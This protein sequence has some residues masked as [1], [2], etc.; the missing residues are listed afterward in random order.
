MTRWTGTGAATL[1][2]G[3]WTLSC[4]S[5]CGARPTRPLRCRDLRDLPGARGVRRL[6]A[7][8]RRALRRVGRAV[9]EPA[10]APAPGRC[11][12]DRL[13]PAS[14]ASVTVHAAG[15]SPSTPTRR[16]IDPT[17]TATE[18]LGD[19]RAARCAK[20]GHRLG[21][22]T[23]GR[24]RR[25]GRRRRRQGRR[26]RHRAPRRGRGPIQ[27]P[28]QTAPVLNVTLPSITVNVPKQKRQKRE[29]QGHRPLSRRPRRRPGGQ[30]RGAGT[31]RSHARRVRRRKDGTMVVESL[32][33]VEQAGRG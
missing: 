28:S 7:G 13:V 12:R 11:S 1:R 22:R 10:Q 4:S 5:R 3:A 19:H 6:R 33:A 26:V 14:V 30:R 24:R 20:R 15:R 2:A 23:V 8:P 17:S 27:R 18:L 31:H 29:R 21:L 9:R 25:Q 32:P 16:G